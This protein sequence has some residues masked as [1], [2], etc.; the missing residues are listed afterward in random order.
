MG[1]VQASVSADA[2]GRCIA[3]DEKRIVVTRPE[4]CRT[5]RARAA[6]GAVTSADNGGGAAGELDASAG[7]GGPSRLRLAPVLAGQ[8]REAV[9][10]LARAAAHRFGV[11]EV[12]ERA[13]QAAAALL[14]RQLA[15]QDGPVGCD[16]VALQANGPLSGL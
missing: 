11:F 14:A 15:R 2:T 3:L 10:G 16:H 5:E 13:G 9:N 12:D 8:A 4:T 1:R 6:Q 7:G